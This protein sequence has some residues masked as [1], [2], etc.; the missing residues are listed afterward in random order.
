LPTT[1][2]VANSHAGAFVGEVSEQ[3]VVFVP[4][5]PNPAQSRL[6][7]LPATRLIAT[8]LTGAKA[9]KSLFPRG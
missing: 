5:S 4:G 9:L 3:F 2:T 8:D 7:R 6:L 1:F